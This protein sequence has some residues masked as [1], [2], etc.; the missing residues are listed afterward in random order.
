MPAMI[1]RLLMSDPKSPEMEEP[2]KDCFWES[3]VLITWRS[4]A[5]SKRN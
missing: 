1:V 2:A 5:R 3:R 4:S